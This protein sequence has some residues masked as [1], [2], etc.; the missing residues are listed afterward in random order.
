MF[1]ETLEFKTTILLSYGM[2]KNFEF[3]I[4]SPKSPSVGHC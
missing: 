3:A 2:Q 4:A 1:E